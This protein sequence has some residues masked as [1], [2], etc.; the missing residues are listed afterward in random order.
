MLFLRYLTDQLRKI[1][2]VNEANKVSGSLCIL[3]TVLALLFFSFSEGCD[4]CLLGDILK[5][6]VV[7]ALRSI[8]EIL[9]YGDQHDPSFFE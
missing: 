7:E 9:T 8:A 4:L 5:D 6:L 3:A 2:V 1:Q